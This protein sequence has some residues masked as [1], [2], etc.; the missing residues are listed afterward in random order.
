MCQSRRLPFPA[1]ITISL[2]VLYYFLLHFTVNHGHSLTEGGLSL[3]HAVAARPSMQQWRFV[4]STLYND[5]H[6]HKSVL[7][8]YRSFT[9]S[10]GTQAAVMPKAGLPPQNQEPKL[11][12]YQGL[13]RCSSFPLLSAFFSRSLACEKTLKDLKISQGHQRGGEKGGFG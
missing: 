1:F 3:Q 4:S 10:A 2:R 6:Y 7:P 5:H 12:F 8:K 9:A 13:N 11:Q